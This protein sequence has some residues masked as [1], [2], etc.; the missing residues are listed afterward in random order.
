MLL[1]QVTVARKTS[2]GGGST[3][4]QSSSWRKVP[5]VIEISIGTVGRD[6]PA[7]HL[8][9]KVIGQLLV[10]RVTGNMGTILNF[11][12]YAVNQELANYLLIL[13]V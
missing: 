3:R 8:T 2:I 9:S 11:S 4:V 7:H 1:G 12:D 6:Q 13:P 10:S 5:F